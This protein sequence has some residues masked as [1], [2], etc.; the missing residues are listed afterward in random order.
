MNPKNEQGFNSPD[1]KSQYI[2]TSNTP[3]FRRSYWVVPGKLLAGCYPSGRNEAS[4]AEKVQGLINAGVS[5]IVCLMETKETNHDGQPFQNY[6][7]G[8]HE[9]ASRLNR[10]VEWERHP[11]VDG[12]ITSVESMQGILN[13]ID[14][15]LSRGRVVYVHC[16]GGRGRT[17][18]VVCCWL[19][20]HGI[21][22]PL[23]AVD[24]M[25]AL[26]GGRIDD[27]RPTPEN[28]VQRAFIEKWKKGL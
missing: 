4:A 25:H 8:I 11:I 22:S 28:A 18:T 9:G 16:W 10:S 15:A 27:F 21:A 6:M 26:I 3:P 2:Q 1:P 7:P 14:S 12:S 23:Q 17:G 13:S 20:R 24:H 19:I 5:A